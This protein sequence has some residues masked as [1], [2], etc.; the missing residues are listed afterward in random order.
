MISM[1]AARVN[2]GYS[3]TE[4]AE[5]MGVHKNTYASWEKGLTDI[6]AKSF[7]VFCTIVNMSMDDIFLPCN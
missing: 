5:K 7:E 1:R 3:Q 6:S 2:A 4:M